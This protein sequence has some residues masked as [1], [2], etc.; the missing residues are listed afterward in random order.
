MSIFSFFFGGAV[1]EGIVF[2]D[3]FYVVQWLS[4]TTFNLM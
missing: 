3:A 4:F 2:S 1:V